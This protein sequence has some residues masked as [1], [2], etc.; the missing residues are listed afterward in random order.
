MSMEPLVICENLVKIYKVA[1][2]ETVAL[3]GLDLTVSRGELLGVVGA[4]GSGKTTLMN[5]LGG[6]DRPSAGRL[7]VDGMD[8]LKMKDTAL[9]HYRRSKVGFVWQQ[10]ARNLVPYLDALDNVAMPMMLSGV[11]RRSARERAKSL[12]SSV[13]LAGRQHHQLMNLSGGEQQRVAIAVA[14]SNRPILLLADEPTGE[15]DTGTAATI[16]ATFR[17]LCRNTGVTILIVSHDQSIARQVDRVVEVRDG[18]L[19][20]ETV[21]NGLDES[22]EQAPEAYQKLVVLD[23]AGRLHIPKEYLEHFK[24]RRRAQLELTEAGI[25]IRPTLQAEQ[26]P[27]QPAVTS[28][29]QTVPARHGLPAY[30]VRWQ[31]LFKRERKA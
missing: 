29:D 15:L 16:Y 27:T 12:L 30:L 7:W 19:A 23:S 18:K 26:D 1:E 8:L 20:S 11:S 24:I 4:S 17:E 14:L 10:A 3:Q 28:P 2:L 6:L 9:D 5:I 31:R 21:R 25:L 13:D 22:G